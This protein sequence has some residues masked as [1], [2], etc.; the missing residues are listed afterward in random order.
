LVGV[1]LS[2]IS[3]SK[4]QQ[5]LDKQSFDNEPILVLSYIN[6][7]VSYFLKVRHFILFNHIIRNPNLSKNAKLHQLQIFSKNFNKS[8]SLSMLTL[9][10]ILIFNTIK[11]KANSHIFLNFSELS[12]RTALE[13]Q[14]KPSQDT[15]YFP[16]ISQFGTSNAT[17]LKEAQVL[18]FS[19][20][21]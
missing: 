4:I 14:F 3:D 15:F 5:Q 2:A 8:L 19:R 16:A 13:E 9:L 17:A 18:F 20:I 21:F 7:E 11:V 12:F 6:K 1:A 10:R